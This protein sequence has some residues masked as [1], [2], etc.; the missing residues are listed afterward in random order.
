[1]YSFITKK[2][3]ENEQ[4]RIE[5][6][7]MERKIKQHI[8]L[9]LNNNKKHGYIFECIVDEHTIFFCHLK[10]SLHMKITKNTSKYLNACAKKKTIY[11]DLAISKMMIYKYIV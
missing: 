11:S 4:M 5:V 6:K 1:M 3:R 2:K 10:Q 7:V 9:L 8:F